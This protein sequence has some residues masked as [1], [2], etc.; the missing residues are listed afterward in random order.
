MQRNRGNRFIALAKPWLAGLFAL[1]WLVVAAES[2]GHHCESEFPSHHEC[3]ACHMAHGAVLADGSVG[4]A[5][6]LPAIS[7]SFQSPWISP[8]SGSSDLRLS[9]GR[10]PPA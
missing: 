6:A 7:N 10:A 8:A 4:V 3:A 9:P 1:M 2:V 5:L